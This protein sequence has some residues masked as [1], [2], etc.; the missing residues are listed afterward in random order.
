[1]SGSKTSGSKT[2]ISS[3]QVILILISYDVN[4][5]YYDNPHPLLVHTILK[6]I[7]YSSVGSSLTSKSLDVNILNPDCNLT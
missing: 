1:M 2:Y 7:S 3:G 4:N 5:Y 6:V